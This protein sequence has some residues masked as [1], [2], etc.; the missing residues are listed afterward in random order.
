M[1]DAVTDK[2]RFKDGRT[3]EMDAIFR[4]QDEQLT[5]SGRTII[6]DKLE[7]KRSANIRSSDELRAEKSS[8]TGIVDLSG[9]GK[10]NPAPRRR[11]RLSF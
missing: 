2:L 3:K 6:S 11:T 5:S 4:A 8:G 9:T 7:L 1:K 10:Y